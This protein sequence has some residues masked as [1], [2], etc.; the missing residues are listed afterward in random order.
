[1]GFKADRSFL[2]F[3]TMGAAG[4][5]Q[6]VAFLEDSGFS[7]IELERYTTSNKIWAT[8]VKRL[9]LADLVCVRTG[10]RFEVRA[11]TDLA[12]RMSDAPSNP[13]RTWDAGLR[14]EDV[15]AFIA[16][17]ERDG[18]MVTAPAPNLFLVKDLRASIGTTRLGP[19]KAASEGAERD[20]TWPSCV[21]SEDGTVLAVTLERILARMKSGRRQTY[22]LKGK[23]P[24][25]A[26]NDRFVGGASIIAGTAERLLKPSDLET[27]TWDPLDALKA[28]RPSDRYVAAKALPFS[29]L[30]PEAI[31]A[32]LLGALEV[33]QDTRVALE[34]AGG[35]LRI[36]EAEGLARLSREIDSGERDDL[37]MEA[38]LILSEI[39][40]KPSARALLAV[41]G[42]EAFRGKEVR[43][44][45]VWGLGHAGMKSYADLVPFLADAEEDVVLHAIAGFAPDAADAVI[46]H[47]VE[48]VMSG[49]DRTR[50]AAI[51]ALRVV[52]GPRVVEK[53]AAAAREST[54]P[55]PI[56]ALGRQRQENVIAVLG[57]EPLMQRVEP[58]LLV[59]SPHRNW[60]AQPPTA[61]RFSFLLGQDLPVVLP[62][63]AGRP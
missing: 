40:T 24:Y 20:R 30:D 2:R 16:C 60:F 34:I 15:I 35:L 58:V 8:K 21:P 41:A 31:R 48:L 62:R 29:T 55:W 12:I 32:S 61:E 10:I 9:R 46:E 18:R 42:K 23:S 1:V 47:L 44:A 5:R 19:P 22:L 53:L 51:E 25:V 11:K 17:R 43:Q 49:D 63:L 59:A 6:T 36:G 7:P 52:G 26:A 50:V 45:A 39:A 28:E 3:L 13:E 27:M 4:T 54:S 14:D 56:A 57:K 37:Q 33:E 38:V